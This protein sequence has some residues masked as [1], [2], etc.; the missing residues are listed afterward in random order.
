[1]SNQISIKSCLGWPH[2]ELTADYRA[3]APIWRAVTEKFFDEMLCALPPLMQSR[4]QFMLGEPYTHIYSN[5][6]EIAVHCALVQVKK[7]GE[8]L[9]FARYLATNE[10]EKEA[11]ALRS[12]VASNAA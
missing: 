4:G 2:H 5:K 12:F 3:Q 11:A 1:M 8:M 7:D 9:Y 6:K 10:F